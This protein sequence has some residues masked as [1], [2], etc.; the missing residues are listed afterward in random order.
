MNTL[1][2][3]V[4]FDEEKMLAN[5]VW[6]NFLYS[7]GLSMNFEEEKNHLA[8]TAVA[9]KGWIMKLIEK[10]YREFQI[11]RAFHFD[12]WFHMYLGHKS[13]FSQNEH[14]FLSAFRAFH[15]TQ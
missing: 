14:V 2:E 6:F 4:F 5:T 11:D 7:E 1:P 13:F 12:S 9:H 10:N 8:Q 15:N 3:N